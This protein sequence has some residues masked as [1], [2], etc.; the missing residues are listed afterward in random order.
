MT[1]E[2]LCAEDLLDRWHMTF[3]LGKE[4]YAL[5]A[6]F[7]TEIVGIQPIATL[8]GA[9]SYVKGVINLRGR[10]MPIT[11]LRKKFGIEPADY[12]DRTC[13]IV[14]EMRQKA[15]GLIVDAA[16]DVVSVEEDEIVMPK[17]CAGAAAHIGGI[18]R[19]GENVVM[20]LDCEQ[21]FKEA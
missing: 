18:A 21:L 17:A 1:T 15:M 5:R 10:V 11:D 9:P 12:T 14:I 8:P 6:R 20:L 16:A 2:Q 13:I 7:V 19:I 3:V 4:T